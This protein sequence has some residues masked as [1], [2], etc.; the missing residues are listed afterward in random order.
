MKSKRAAVLLVPLLGLAGVTAYL[1]V[2]TRMGVH[3]MLDVLAAGNA[4]AMDY[5]TETGPLTLIS[6]LE[7]IDE[8]TL[9]KAVEQPSGIQH[10]GDTV[11]I[12]TDQVELFVLSGD[13]S[14]VSRRQELVS[15]L[16]IFK[17]GQL[18][19]IEYVDDEVLLAGEFGAIWVW[20]NNGGELTRVDDIVLPSSI[21]NMELSGMTQAS[22]R[23]LAVS[24]ETT[25]VLDL[26]TGA[27]LELEFGD[28]LKEGAD[29]SALK[30][31]GIAS[32]DGKLYILSESHSCILVV[33]STDFSVNAVYGIKP[34]PVADLAVR[35][36][37]AYVIVDHNYT[38]PKP[39]VY[40]YNLCAE[41]TAE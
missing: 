8:I 9:P 34:G 6:T 16:L 26:S 7:P 40:V 36:G 21:G 10:R 24:D 39:P 5:N 37:L 19:S 30:Y 11:Y 31:C 35:D 14:S 12:A 32:E 23:L 29:P 15:G 1:A 18:E 22:D 17:Q 4:D 25:M 41:Q 20:E 33:D 27:T 13:F 2:N 38:E 28:F 3:I